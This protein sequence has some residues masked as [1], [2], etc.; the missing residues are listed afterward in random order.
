MPEDG[1]GAVGGGVRVIIIVYI[2]LLV[3]C[4][5]CNGLTFYETANSLARA[6]VAN[7]VRILLLLLLYPP[8]TTDRYVMTRSGGVCERVMEII[9]TYNAYNVYYYTLHRI[10]A[11]FAIDF[12]RQIQFLEPDPFPKI[13]RA[14]ACVCTRRKLFMDRPLTVYK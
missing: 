6:T 9:I 1:I 12:G 13:S 14:R 10:R 5:I 3:G 2:L 11:R 8:R 7:G 4:Q